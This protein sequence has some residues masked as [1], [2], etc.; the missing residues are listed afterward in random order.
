MGSLE[1]EQDLGKK[2]PPEVSFLTKSGQ[3]NPWIANWNW[4]FAPPFSNWLAFALLLTW[5][6]PRKT[7]KGSQRALVWLPSLLTLSQGRKS[8]LG[9]RKSGLVT[10]PSSKEKERSAESRR[11]PILDK[12][13]L[14]SASRVRARQMSSLPVRYDR[15]G[16]RRNWQRNYL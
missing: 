4:C 15:S 3:V 10:R 11:T 12:D 16:S 13:P 5:I 6:L 9:T 1:R 14:P 7:R 8:H 2:E